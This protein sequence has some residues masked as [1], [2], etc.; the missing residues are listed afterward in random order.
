MRKLLRAVEQSPSTVIITDTAGNIEYVNPRFTQL[1][2]Y[3]QK[4]AIGKNPRILQSGQTPRETY[5]NL[6]ETVT[7]GREW[8]GEFLNKKK[9]GEFYW[10]SASISALTQ[11]N[12]TVTHYV[13]VLE[14]ITARKKM[15]QLKEEFAGNVSHELR[16]PLAAIKMSAEDLK[17]GLSG[18]LTEE[19]SEMVEIILRNSLRLQ[20][21][22]NEILDLS[23]L[24]S[25]KVVVRSEPVDIGPPL[26]EVIRNFRKMTGRTGLVLELDLP[27]RLPAPDADPDMIVQLLNNLLDNAARF[28]RERVVVKATAGTD[29]VQVS[30]IDDGPG[31]AKEDQQRLFSRFEQIKRFKGQNGYQGTGLGLTICKEIVNQHGGK[32]WVESDPGSGARFHFTLPLRKEEQ[33]GREATRGA[34]KEENCARH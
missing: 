7:S 32:I 16:T 28:A 33:E 29:F 26:G 34:T 19:Q 1:T 15:E 8:H 24:E 21:I 9:N 23:R 30:V 4:E 20:K 22:V 25:G 6:W 18:L 12:G 14:D 5:R 3:A 17:D 31:I 13:G 27:E 11:S 2:G 10:E